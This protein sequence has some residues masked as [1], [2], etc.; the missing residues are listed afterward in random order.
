[1]F[2]IMMAIMKTIKTPIMV[3][4]MTIT[5]MMIMSSVITIVIMTNYDED[6]CNFFDDAD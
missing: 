6:K 5:I 3:K 2:V 4:I 1:M